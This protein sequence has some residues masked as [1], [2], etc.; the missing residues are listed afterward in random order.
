LD[1]RICLSHI[2][3]NPSHHPD[4]DFKLSV[5]GKIRAK[6]IIVETGWSDFV[7]E[8]NYYLRSIDEVETYITE[9][10]HLPDVPSA[11][12]VEENGINVGE[13]NALLLQKIEELT[14][15]LIKQDKE[16]QSLKK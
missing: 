15:Y 1:Q 4:P 6:E 5:N 16:I 12:E 8:E 13:M 3:E 2:V 10:G 7:F 11:D 14:L 9:N